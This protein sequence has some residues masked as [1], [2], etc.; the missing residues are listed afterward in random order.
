MITGL[1][2]C[3]GRQAAGVRRRRTENL[4][5]QGIQ[6]SP[7]AQ[8]AET[9]LSCGDESLIQSQS[10]G[11]LPGLSAWT[12]VTGR[13]PPCARH[14]LCCHGS[15]SDRFLPGDPGR[16]HGPL[17]WCLHAAISRVWSEPFHRHNAQW[18]QQTLP[19]GLSLIGS[20]HLVRLKPSKKPHLAVGPQ[21]RGR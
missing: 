21:S 17:R 2:L 11:A 9:R 5:S 6:K 16:P 13:P 1:G 18:L 7:L 14:R 12:G 15:Y 4:G 10:Q 19:A 20:E 8:H 3:D